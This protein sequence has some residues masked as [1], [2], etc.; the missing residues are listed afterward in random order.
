MGSYAVTA[1]WSVVD[2]TSNLDRTTVEPRALVP[3]G[4]VVR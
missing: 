4:P 1:V 3:T 2:G